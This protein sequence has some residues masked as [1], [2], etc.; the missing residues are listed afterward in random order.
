MGFR[1]TNFQRRKIR[2]DQSFSNHRSAMWNEFYLKCSHQKR[3]FE[4]HE[5]IRREVKLN[6]EVKFLIGD[7]VIA[8]IEEVR[9]MVVSP[10]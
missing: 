3:D 8:M 4:S 5:R 6:S 2:R 7:E 9:N 1:G 10:L